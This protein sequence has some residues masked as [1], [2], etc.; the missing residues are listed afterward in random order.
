MRR[1][2]SVLPFV[3][4]FATIAA[5]YIWTTRSN[6]LWWRFGEEQKDYYN[7]LVHGFLDGHLSLKADVPEA[8]LHAADPYDP[9]K[10]P[11]GIALHDA[12]LY[13]GKYYIYYGV[14]PAVVALLPFRLITGIDLP[15][16][17]AVLGFALTSYAIALVLIAALRRRYFPRCGRFLTF[18]LAVGY[19]FASCAPILLRRSSMY[20]LPITCGE[21][22]AMA[23]LVSLYLAMVQTSRRAAWLALSSLGWGLAIG[24]R[25]TYL[26][27]PLGLALAY[28]VLFRDDSGIHVHR[29]RALQLWLAAIVPI[30][31][32]GVLLAVYNYERFG[33]PTEFGVSYILSGVYEAKIE[34]FRLRYVTWNIRGYFLATGE[35]GRYF[36]FFHPRAIAAARPL[37]HYGMDHPFGLLANVPIIW[38]AIF[39]AGRVPVDADAQTRRIR[40]V[41][42]GAML[43][44]ALA[45]AGLVLC[46]YAAMARYLGDFAPALALLGVIGGMTLIERSAAAISP[47]RRRTVAAL[48]AAQVAITMF[49]VFTV[50]VE[51]YGRL[52]VFNPTRYAALAKVA[53]APVH[54]IES[55]TGSAVGPL[56]LRLKFP[57]GVANRREELLRTG[58]SEEIDRVSVEY[59]DAKHV[60][61]AYDH[62]GA[63]TVRSEPIVLDRAT[64]HTIT[65]SMGSLFPPLTSSRFES[66]S[67]EQIARVVRR[68]E[69]KVDG[70]IALERYQRFYDASA[71]TLVLGGKGSAMPFSGQILEVKRQPNLAAPASES[72]NGAPPFHADRDGTWRLLVRISDVADGTREPLIVS[73]ETG[74]GDFLAVEHLAGHRLRFILD[75]W[76]SRALFSEPIAYEPNR[77]YTIAIQHAAF[78]SLG[79]AVP[80]N[81]PGDLVITLDGKVVWRTSVMLYLVAPEDVF[82]GFNPIGGSS[83]R[84]RFSGTIAPAK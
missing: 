25:P 13:R 7:L 15:V 43:W 37:Q 82:V 4:A 45:V 76:G 72:S 48:I 79:G 32:I 51:I 40:C 77:E 47:W 31:T 80:A 49:V 50:S 69:I 62:T 74:R 78:R 14:I 61:L 60:C 65:V 10:R 21:V 16:P 55:L 17:A 66:W 39:A 11:E 19:G 41:L 30:A 58:W 24:C 35:W 71:G 73:G 29:R 2:W 59:P 1:F 52:R 57:A 18:F 36:P 64:E 44:A 6:N 27:A 8:L 42:L 70:A 46:F 12:S 34:H 5:T 83:C 26:F 22:C 81:T 20:E 63:P 68:L 54:W 75:H 53:N 84:E 28:P 9:A 23:A 33:S 38:L 67:P 3:A 56:E